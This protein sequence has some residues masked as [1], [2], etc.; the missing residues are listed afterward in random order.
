MVEN[1]NEIIEVEGEFIK[2]VDMMKS[3]S[4]IEGVV[5]S[6]NRI[7]SI[8]NSVEV[9]SAIKNVKYSYKDRVSTK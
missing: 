8:L 2:P 5:V 7:I 9:L 1:T 3:H 4:L 6:G